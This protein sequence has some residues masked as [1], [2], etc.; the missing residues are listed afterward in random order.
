MY[1]DDCSTPAAYNRRWRAGETHPRLPKPY[2][3]LLPREA[4]CERCGETY[5]QT[6]ARQL[7]CGKGSCGEF[8]TA[9]CDGCGEPF[10]ARARDREPGWARFCGKPCALRTRRAAERQ[11]VA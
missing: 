6:A 7:Y 3:R 1:C 8:V 4:V 2:V 11:A 5:T 10:E 9:A